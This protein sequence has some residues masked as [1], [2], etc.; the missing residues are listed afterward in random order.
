VL[1]RF[2]AP[3]FRSPQR[4]NK[5]PALSAPGRRS[6]FAYEGTVAVAEK[7]IRSSF[8]LEPEDPRNPALGSEGLDIARKY[9]AGHIA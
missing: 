2:S 8:V 7:S 6:V 1:T 9:A 5:N 3:I 4:R